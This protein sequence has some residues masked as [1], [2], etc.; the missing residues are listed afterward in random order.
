[1]TRRTCDPVPDSSCDGLVQEDGLDRRSSF[2]DSRSPVLLGGRREKRI[3]SKLRA[4]AK[5]V[6]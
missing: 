1:M 5:T 6:G 2:R 3:W 4:T